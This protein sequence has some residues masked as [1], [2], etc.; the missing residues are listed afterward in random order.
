[1]TV[2]YDPLADAERE[3]SEKPGHEWVRDPND[4]L[5]YELPQ[6]TQ[7][8]SSNYLID[9]NQPRS[10][11]NGDY[12]NDPLIQ[13]ARSLPDR[14]EDPLLAEP[15]EFVASQQLIPTQQEQTDPTAQRPP[16]QRGFFSSLAD[17]DLSDFAKRFGA[18][19]LDLLRSQGAGALGAMGVQPHFALSDEQNNALLEVQRQLSTP[20]G[21]AAVD[22][23]LAAQAQQLR[24]ST[25]PAAQDAASRSYVEAA[26]PGEGV[27]LTERIASLAPNNPLSIVASLLRSAMPNTP[28]IG[29]PGQMGDAN[30]ATVA[31]DIA[32]SLPSVASGIGAGGVT[33]KALRGGADTAPSTTRTGTSMCPTRS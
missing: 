21:R 2:A 13:L 7:R 24:A 18:G 15:G 22:R 29:R 14:D 19:T 12:D 17:L 10:A 1:M 11:A 4:G 31:L 25:S 32:E 3:P 27:D 26:P 28:F 30:A 9:P 8:S 33:T 20:E 6:I 5:W 23:E 16:K